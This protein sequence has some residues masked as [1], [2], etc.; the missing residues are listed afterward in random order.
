MDNDEIFKQFDNIEGKVE[1][2]INVCKSL[3]M[4]NT[5]LL[6]KVEG[7]EKEIQSKTKVENNYLEQKALVKSKIEN[8]IIKL[9][10]FSKPQV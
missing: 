1:N 5:E 4:E 6:Q 10:E 2:L 3:K 7:L 9:N 8:L